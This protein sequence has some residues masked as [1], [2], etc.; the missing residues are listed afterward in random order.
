MNKER[1]SIKVIIADDH[2]LFVEGI[3]SIFSKE[4]EINFIDCA[5]NGVELLQKL[6]IHVPEVL[7]LD[8][9][10]PGI[11]GI[12][13]LKQLKAANTSIKILMLSTYAD[14][15]TIQIC[16]ENGADGY[17]FKNASFDE[18]RNAILGTKENIRFFPPQVQSADTEDAKFEFYA[19]SF[20]I[21]KSEYSIMKLIRAGF[22]N[23][24]ISDTQNRS[25]HTIE[26]HR[27]N[28]MQ[29][30][31]LK[32]PSSITKYLIENDF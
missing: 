11:D 2:Q 6:S 23:Q 25:V 26:T 5:S 12:T 16:I 22:T 7:L 24:K 21:T 3:M 30:L 17:L 20:N 9:K 1:D 28:L 19:K 4:K 14:F 15:Q 31:N 27:R 32:F 29:K 13:I 10:M 18:L 8:I